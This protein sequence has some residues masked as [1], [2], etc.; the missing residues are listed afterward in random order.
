MVSERS[1][2]TSPNMKPAI[3]TND[4]ALAAAFFA[5]GRPAALVERWGRHAGQANGHKMAQKRQ[6]GSAPPGITMFSPRCIC[7]TTKELIHEA[8][9]STRSTWPVTIAVAVLAL[10]LG[11]VG[12]AVAGPALTEARSRPSRPRW[13]RRRRRSSPWPRP[14]P[15]RPGASPVPRWRRVSGRSRPRGRRG[16]GRRV[17]PRGHERADQPGG[18]TGLPRGGRAVLHAAPRGDGSRADV[19]RAILRRLLAAARPAVST[20]TASRCPAPGGASRRSARRRPSSWSGAR[21]S[22]QVLTSCAT[23]STARAA[24]TPARRSSTPRGRSCWP[25]SAPGGPCQAGSTRLPS[26]S[27]CSSTFLLGCTR[28]GSPGIFG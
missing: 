14:T 19:R 27:Q 10:A 20:S 21:R 13:S 1:N 15:S 3:A 17:H 6:A 7:R 5:E 2:T 12:T 22:Q 24:P 28:G 18:R 11:S 23:A 8:Q 16:A 4:S 9:L 25:P 26:A